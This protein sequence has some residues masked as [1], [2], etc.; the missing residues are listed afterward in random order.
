MNPS[1]RIS[2]ILSGLLLIASLT[3]NRARCQEQ[4]IDYVPQE[5]FAAVLLDLDKLAETP[6]SEFFPHEIITAYAK[7]DYGFD[8]TDVE[9]AKMIIAINENLD[10]TPMVGVIIKLKKPFEIPDRLSEN[11]PPTNVDGTKIY[12][13]QNLEMHVVQPEPKTLLL[14]GTEPFAVL[15]SASKKSRTPFTRLLAETK[16]KNTLTLVASVEQLK[17]SL[18]EKIREFPIP[19]PFGALNRLP[20]QLKAVK[21]GTDVAPGLTFSLDLIAYGESEAKKIEKTYRQLLKMGKA[22][23]LTMMAAQIDSDDPIQQAQYDYTMRIADLIEDQLAPKREKNVVSIRFKNEIGNIGV[24]VALLLPAVQSAREAARRTQA[25]NDLKQTALA[26]HNYHD[27]HGHF[28]A[29]AITDRKGKKLLSWRVE[30]L[31]Y[32]GYEKLYEQFHLDEPWD[33]PHNI[34]LLNQIPPVYRN[35]NS[36][37]ISETNILAVAGKGTA[38][39][40]RK[41]IKISDIRDGTSNTILFVESNKF[42]PWTKPV[43]HEVDWDNPISDLGGIRPGIFQATFAD[44]SVQSISINVDQ[45]V[46]KSLFKIN[47]GK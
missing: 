27:V 41:G 34:K 12:F 14:A 8:P 29:Q 32:L 19:A 36:D 35:P 40:G 28:P 22:S 15:M 45:E 1:L 6:G 33:S 11:G 7:R 39:D 38:F 10:Q 26:F 21:A 30:V 2:T 37:K 44:G 17:S 24:L 20:E 46:L 5:T 25:A 13:D 23:V 16:T 47:D 18:Q 4:S 31:P 9:S 3:T 42:V 43:D